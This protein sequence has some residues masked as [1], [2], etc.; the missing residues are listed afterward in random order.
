MGLLDT[1]AVSSVIPIETWRRRGFDKDNLID[2]NTAVS[3][4][5]GGA[6]G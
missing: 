5:Q 4:K 2:K 3:S 1:G 6:S